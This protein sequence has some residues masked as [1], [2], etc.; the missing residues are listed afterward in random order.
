M[1]LYPPG[2]SRG[3]RDAERAI[4]TQPRLEPAF[5]RLV[6]EPQ[7]L[8]QKL[9]DIFSFRTRC[10]Q[11]AEVEAPRELPTGVTRGLESIALLGTA[12]YRGQIEVWVGHDERPERPPLGGSGEPQSL[13]AYR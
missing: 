7:L 5:E 10:L 11:T 2:R 4:F 9:G 12:G 6:C 13:P 3:L 1:A 8:P